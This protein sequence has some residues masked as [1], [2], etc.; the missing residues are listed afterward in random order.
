MRN[1][2]IDVGTD[3]IHHSLS[4]ADAL[5]L[6]QEH[7]DEHGI[8]VTVWSTYGDEETVEPSEGKHD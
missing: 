7:A 3:T 5:V 1:Y 4:R 8:T 2:S 6:A